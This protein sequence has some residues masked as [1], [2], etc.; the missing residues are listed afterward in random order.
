MSPPAAER[1][2]GRAVVGTSGIDMRLMPGATAAWMATYVALGWSAGCSYRLAGVGLA[3]AVL[4]LLAGRGW[5]VTVGGAVGCAA[6]ALLLTGLRV[7]ARD[8]SPLVDLAK[9]HA[10]VE[11]MLV[12]RD[13]PHPLARSGTNGGPQ[14]LVAATARQ[15]A[16]TD[17]SW[18]LS[19][20]VL[21]F[22]PAGSWS[23]LLPS[24]HVRVRGRLG[25][26]LGGDLTTAVISVVGPPVDVGP[27][28]GPQRVADRLRSGLRASSSGL[29][30]GAAG[31]LPG[32]VVGDVSTLDPAL[33][34]DFRTAGLSHL[35]A[36]S[37]ANL[38]ILAGAVLLLCRMVGVG[39]RLS[40][41]VSGFATVGFVVLARPSPSVLRAAVMG[42]IALVALALGRPRAALPALGGSVLFLL[43]WQP[44]LARS[45]GFALSVLATAALV[46]IA[47]R[48]TAGLRDR[49][50][51]VVVA[52]A[53][54]TAAAAGMLTAPV[55]AAL[56]GSVST[57]AIPAN[58]LA[59]PAVAPAT[60]L[61]VLAVLVGPAWPAGA[62]A[63]AW[64]AGLPAAWIVTVARNA[65][66]LPGATI[67]WPA[68]AAGAATLGGVL[69]VMAWLARRRRIRRL[70]LAVLAGV[71]VVVLPVRAVT[72][73]WPPPG[74][75]ITA[76]D[77]GQ[78]DALV[79]AA[80]V[81]VGVVVDAG[82]DPAAVDGCLHRLG[83]RRIPLVVLT[84][85]HADHVAGLPGV[86][87]DRAVG[88][89]EVGPLRQPDWAWR[90][91]LNE[92]EAAHV[93]M[94]EGAVGEVRQVANLRIALIGPRHAF[95]GTRSD[96]NNSSLVLR[97]TTGGHSM[98]LTGDAEVEAQRE[99]L[100]DD[101]ADL[102]AEILKVPHHG[103]AYS[104]PDFIAAVRPG[105]GIV[106]V[107]AHND[108]GHPSAFLL[109]TLSR[110]GVR[111]ERTDLDG[112][113]AIRDHGGGLEVVT[114]SRSPP[115][116]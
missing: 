53:F 7:S 110:L 66:S 26:S 22:A 51:P 103:S 104:L 28:S 69:V 14:V 16:T 78:G 63:V 93:P 33:R 15:V 1:G 79:L 73:G 115:P 19:A 55:I 54:A 10:T 13:D 87:R 24:Q 60:V 75:L 61:G 59:A 113:I 9:R 68:G 3:L 23:A 94:L 80:G 64:L 50:V 49:G 25:P 52:E 58:L 21:V 47:P 76:C 100:R 56:G 29:P 39:P 4:G 91:V 89:I 106:S 43:A 20:P 88:A 74:W 36:A 97:V 2:A 48:W 81:G 35:L 62:H 46:V 65:A 18:T 8:A 41:L 67:P 114:R 38:A 83:I 45:A 70:A 30:G 6:A 111:A 85:L 107:G 17:E 112:D 109:A 72:P 5:T 42:G 37:G 57:V 27:P 95:H 102:P 92:A 84:H 44:E 101:S 86:L 82:P 11:A 34:D 12:L 98:L 90:S 99:L 105:I 32:L 77:V 71:T 31:L 40:A 116:G 96:P 108:Y